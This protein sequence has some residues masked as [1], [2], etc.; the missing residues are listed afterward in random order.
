MQHL[1]LFGPIKEEE[2][3]AV[4]PA[5]QRLVGCPKNKEFLETGGLR[6]ET[7]GEQFNARYHVVR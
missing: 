3:K 6:A 1:F 5:T 2:Q 7:I 4:P